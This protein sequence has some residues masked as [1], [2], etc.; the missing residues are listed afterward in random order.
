MG[1]TKSNN[2]VSI[3]EE[4]Y[5]S[6]METIYLAPQRKLVDKI[7]EGENEDFSKMSKFNKEEEW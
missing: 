5:N 6:I 2:A 3:S 4:D 7:K 1:T